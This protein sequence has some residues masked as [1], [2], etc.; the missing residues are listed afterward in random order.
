MNLDKLK[1]GSD[2]LLPVVIADATTGAVLTLAWADRA[3]LE[4]TIATRE[5]HLY[6][7]SRQAPWRKGESSGN[8]Q[9]VREVNADCD[10]DA[11]LYSVEPAGPACHTGEP[12]CFHESL[13]MSDVPVR[14][15][16]F[17]LAMNVLEAVL[18]QRKIDPPEGSYVAKLYAGGVDRIGKKIG[19][20]ATEVVIA[21]K[22]DDPDELVWES[23]DLLF[24]LLVML[25]ERNVSLGR[26]G[27]HLLQRVKP[28]PD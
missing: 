18:V 27:E 12:T 1:W 14:D 24:H 10:G 19:E 23:A 13:L 16:R 3:A 11:L 4:R 8:T 26:V 2:G 20:E 21:A 25:A 15:E 6:S 5:T 7:R 17:A 28:D 9:R 22:N